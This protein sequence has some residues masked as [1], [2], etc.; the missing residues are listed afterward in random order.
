MLAIFFEHNFV[1][2]VSMAFFVCVEFQKFF[3][4]LIIHVEA[5]WM[6][7]NLGILFLGCLQ[8]Y[9]SFPIWGSIL[10]FVLLL[11]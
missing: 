3:L 5:L 6:G 11:I 9:F 8:A 2:I 1:R 7:L 4:D 10:G